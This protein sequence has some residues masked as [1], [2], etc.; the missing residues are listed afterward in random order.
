MEQIKQMGQSVIRNG[1]I[2]FLLSIMSFQITNAQETNKLN[3]EQHLIF[4]SVF[5]QSKDSLIL[6]YFQTF[7]YESWMSLVWDKEFLKEDG[8][9]FCT[10]TDPT[11]KEAFLELKDRLEKL[12]VKSFNKK[13]LKK[14]FKLKRNSKKEQVVKISE[15]LIIGEYAFLFLKSNTDKSLHVQKKDKEGNWH[16]ECGVPLVFELH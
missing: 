13:S 8:I 4:T 2:L 11:L 12:E 3:Y 9:A 7:Q 10:F 5:K 6:V 15:P 16:Y 1:L 14:K